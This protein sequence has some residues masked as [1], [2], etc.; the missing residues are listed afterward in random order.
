MVKSG[1]VQEYSLKM[2]PE[3][4]TNILNREWERKREADDN[5]ILASAE[6]T[7]I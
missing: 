7:S 3:G 4:L 5:K 6:Y 1:R 2:E